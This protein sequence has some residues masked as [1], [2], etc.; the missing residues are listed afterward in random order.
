M[1]DIAVRFKNSI[2]IVY[3]LYCIFVVDT[4]RATPLYTI[5]QQTK[6]ILLNFFWI[7]VPKGGKLPMELALNYT[8]CMIGYHSIPIVDYI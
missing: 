7:C 4:Y 1:E 8:G 2:R 6:Q 5:I 3:K